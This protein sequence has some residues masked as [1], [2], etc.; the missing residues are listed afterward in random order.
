MLEKT[1][2]ETNKK[3]QNLRSN[4]FFLNNTEICVGNVYDAVYSIALKYNKSQKAQILC[5][6]KDFSLIGSNIFKALKDVGVN[7]SVLLIEDVDYNNV[8]KSN[9]FNFNED[10]V[11]AVGCEQ[12]ISLALYYAGKRK[13]DCHAVLTEPSC[14]YVFTKSVKIEAGA[15]PL[16]VET[17]PFKSVT[18]DVNVIKKASN[19]CF[20]AAY[21]LVISKLLA[22]IDYKMYLLLNGKSLDKENYNL[23]KEA[24]SLVANISTYKNPKE[25][26]IY[27]E[28]VIALIR[29]KSEVLNDFSLELF[30]DTLCTT[31]LPY[32]V[33]ERT[34]TAFLKLSPLYHMFFSNDFSDII[35][36][37]NYVKDCYELESITG[38]FS[39]IFLKNVK[40]PSNRRLKLTSAIINKTKDGFKKE[41]SSV[42][43]ILNTVKRIYYI[44][45]KEEKEFE[46]PPYSEIK[47]ALKLCTYL[48][49][50]ESVLKVFRD[51][52]VLNCLD[53]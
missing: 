32:S 38:K 14:E 37:P 46:L 24:I 15:I 52:G 18:Y 21:I 31:T 33:G 17:T 28:A 53:A 5:R 9:S 34:L 2:F 45:S 27:A 35:S 40:I 43:S 22:L 47:K 23:A 3:F 10:Y 6:E 13:V 49:D 30:A 19:S 41:T 26:L 8:K 50:K 11:I 39:G 51:M 4:E 42:L 36:M 25:V 7:Y 29:A 16:K 44:L 20:A 48:S 12:L 1:V